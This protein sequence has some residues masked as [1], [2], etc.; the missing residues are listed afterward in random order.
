MFRFVAGVHIL[1]MSSKGDRLFRSFREAALTLLAMLGTLACAQW[2]EAGAGSA[3]LAV[4]LSLSLARSHLAEGR[5]GRWEA[6]LALPLVSLASVGVGALLR[7][8]PWAGATVFVVLMASSIWMRRFGPLALRAGS[9]IALPLVT[10]L[11][12]PPLP[13]RDGGALAR[14]L[15]PVAVA[16]AA[17]AWVTLAEALGR[18]IGWLAPADPHAIDDDASPAPA[19]GALRPSP[20]TRMAL[21]MAAALAASFA[22]GAA[23]FP[24]HW[25]WIVL[26]AFIVNSGNR[27]RQDVVHKSA[28]RVAGAAAGTVA[29]L[30]LA[31]FAAAQGV[32]AAALILACVFLAVWLRPLGY[33]WWALFVTLALALLQGVQPAVAAPLSLLW[34]RLVE[35]GIGAVIG[36]AAAWFVL[37]IRSTDVLR[38]RLADALAAMSEALDPQR[39]A[40]SPAP[41]VAALRRVEQLRPSFHAR[42]LALRRWQALQPADWIDALVACEAPVVALV[43]RGEAPGAVRQA[44]GVA[45]KAMREPAEIGPALEGL[46]AALRPANVPS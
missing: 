3:V 18:R 20:H 17:L 33:G 4:V 32:V 19:A 5:R 28:L 46:R 40:R 15:V 9:L 21:Q 10:L 2:L 29:A 1:N 37:P 42:R 38:R 22:V 13:A 31:G 43:E 36:I 26:T 45:R 16:L 30:A 24:S 7:H 39:A 12:A 41:V 35:I 25:S 27:G 6:L 11:V 34:Q 14:V 23:F 8:V 44:I